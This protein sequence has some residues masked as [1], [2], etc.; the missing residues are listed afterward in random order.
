[1]TKILATGLYEQRIYIIIKEPTTTRHALMCFTTIASGM[2]N[3]TQA[4]LGYCVS[5][6]IYGL[7][8]ERACRE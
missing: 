3:T 8:A 1:M 4:Y 6:S 7:L 2:R 5:P